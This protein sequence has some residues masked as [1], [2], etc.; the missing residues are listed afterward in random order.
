MDFLAPY[1][2]RVDGCFDE[3]F[4]VFSK[5]VYLYNYEVAVRARQAN[6]QGRP[7]ADQNIGA[8]P[9]PAESLREESRA[10]NQDKDLHVV[11]TD[12]N[13]S[14][15]SPFHGIPVEKG[16]LTVKNGSLDKNAVDSAN[17]ESDIVRMEGREPG[18]SQ[19]RMYAEKL[20]KSAQNMHPH[21]LNNQLSA[22][23]NAAETIRF[24]RGES[25]KETCNSLA[26]KTLFNNQNPEYY[27]I[28]DI[29]NGLEHSLA[30]INLHNLQIPE[31]V[32]YTKEHLLFCRVRGVKRTE[33]ITGKG[34]HSKDGIPKL[35]PALMEFLACQENVKVKK[36]KWNSG[37][38][39]VQIRDSE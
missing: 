14:R 29:P 19:A 17:G 34:N 9:I 2:R 36:H 10:V 22:E 25:L 38:L 15:Q 3:M 20:R 4:S 28:P 26:A 7:L 23:N 12:E 33:I 35:K 27:L 37:R 30:E 16:V 8:F 39:V 31:A 11:Q 6:P 18:K 13:L 1:L 21:M 5:L 24:K 32:E